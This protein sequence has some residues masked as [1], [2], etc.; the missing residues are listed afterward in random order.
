M[1]KY[2]LLFLVLAIMVFGQIMSKLG[3]AQDT[4]LNIFIFLG[5]SALI[6][7]GVLWTFALKDVAISL[8]Y[9]LLSLSFVLIL[10]VSH[11][12][13][14]EPLTVGKVVGSALIIAGVILTS[15][16]KLKEEA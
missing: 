2:L 10:G 12:L 15:M 4:L 14:N 6:L 1:K 8:A 16:S 13:F 3:S 9:P 7:R 11:L 5:Y